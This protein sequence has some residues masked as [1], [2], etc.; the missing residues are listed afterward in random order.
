[1][2]HSELI[3]EHKRLVK[4][5]E[6]GNLNQRH[7]EAEIQEKELKHYES[8]HHDYCPHCRKRREHIKFAGY[9]I[10]KHC[11]YQEMY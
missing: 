11:S 6:H 9:K 10:C 7:H 3:K 1:M 4:V 5:L 8:K 2:N